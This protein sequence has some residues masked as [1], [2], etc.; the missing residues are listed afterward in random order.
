M[1]VI[2]SRTAAEAKNLVV[3]IEKRLFAQNEILRRFAPQNY[4]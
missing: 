3:C 2:L 4:T 1:S